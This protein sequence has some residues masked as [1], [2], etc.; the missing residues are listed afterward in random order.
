MSK[1]K[2]TKKPRAD[3]YEP[4]VVINATFSEAMQVLADHAH[5]MVEE[6]QNEPKEPSQQL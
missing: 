6:A 1:A 3:K 2:K 5:K 4:K